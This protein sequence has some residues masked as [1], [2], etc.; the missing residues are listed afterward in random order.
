MAAGCDA[1]TL[2]AVDNVVGFYK[3]TGALT[4]SKAHLEISQTA[5]ARAFYGFGDDDDATAIEIPATVSN[6]ENGEIYDLMGRR[7]EGQPTRKGIYVKN[8]RKIIIK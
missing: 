1:Y 3:F 2:A 4:A 7:I 8:G 6:I 5:G